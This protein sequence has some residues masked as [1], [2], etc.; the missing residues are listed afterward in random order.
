MQD[1]RYDFITTVKN[2]V[3]LYVILTSNF[4]QMHKR[5]Q[6][7]EGL[8]YL[9]TVPMSYTEQAKILLNILSSHMSAKMAANEIRTQP[10]QFIHLLIWQAKK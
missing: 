8:G 2:T 6:V 10:L 4:Q 7:Q 3:T 9:Q 1:T 5:Q